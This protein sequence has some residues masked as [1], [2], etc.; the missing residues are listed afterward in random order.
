MADRAVSNERK[1]EL[2]Q[3][4]PFQENL[5]KAMAFIKEHKRQLIFA[6]SAV[7]LVV[8]VFSGIMYSFERAENKA[9]GLVGQALKN[10]S[11]LNDPDKGFVEVE[12][13]FKTIFNEYSNTNAGRQARIQFAKICYDA[14]K[15]DLSFQYYT[16]A[17]EIFKHEAQMENLIL[18]SLGNVCIAKKEFEEAK[19]YFRKIEKGK[20]EL[21]KDEAMYSLAMLYEIESNASESKKMYEKIISDFESS[22]YTPIAKSKLAQMK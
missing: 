6:I 11:E 20:S 13:K 10:Y 4:D 2:E 14:A 8:V 5:L 17:L 15:Y 3:L 9:A 21:L 19:K 22:M 1:R 12:E 16:Q 7:A 18:S